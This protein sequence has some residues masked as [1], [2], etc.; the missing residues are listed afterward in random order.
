MIN[1]EHYLLLAGD[2]TAWD[3]EVRYLVDGGTSLVTV[4]EDQH[5]RGRRTAE[6]IRGAS[7]W[8]IRTGSGLDDASLLA[9][10][11][12]Q[13]GSLDGSYTAA[14]TWGI[15]WAHA[16][17]FR[18][19]LIMRRSLLAEVETTINTLAPR[20]GPHDAAAAIPQSHRL[21]A[22]PSPAPRRRTI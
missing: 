11:E 14:V 16:D 9:A 10:T 2:P 20:Q 4:Q 6:L 12:Q 13:G 18:R 15:A 17:P 21:P 5:R 3:T 19:E 1:A 22:A 7:G 8:C